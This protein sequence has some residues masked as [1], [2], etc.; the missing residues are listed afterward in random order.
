MVTRR[1]IAEV[2]MSLSTV[3]MILSGRGERY[4][5]ESRDK[6]KKREVKDLTVDAELI[7]RESVA[8]PC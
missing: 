5:Q 1:H 7:M 4:S 2:G 8:D 3:S 6:I